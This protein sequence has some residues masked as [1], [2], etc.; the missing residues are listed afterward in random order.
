MAEQTPRAETPRSPNGVAARLLRWPATGDVPEQAPGPLTLELYPTLRCNL[1]CRFCDTTERHRPPVDELST[2]ELERIVDEAAALGV[3]R[4]F[5][6]GG[7]EPLAR[8]DT[9]ALMQRVKEH[10]M[11]G[12]LTT[13][14]TLLGP[15]VA[16]QLVETGWDEV[17]VSL[18]GPSPGVHDP[19]RGQPGAFRKT[20]QAACRLRVLRDRA[21][22]PTPR[23]AVHF[24]L[25]NENWTTLVE[26]VELAHAIGAERI[27]VDALIAY[28]PEQRA[29]C[30]SPEQQT[31]VPAV[32]Q[33][34]LARAEALGVAS[35]LHH[36]LDAATLNRGETAVA[37]APG[38]GLDGAPCLKAWHYLVVQADGRTSPC[39]VLA[40]E[41]GSVR[42]Q[43]LRD[44]WQADPFLL[45]VREGMSRQRPLPRCSECS[46]NILSHEAAIRDALV[47]QRAGR[48][49]PHPGTDPA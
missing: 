5:V 33:Q 43:S 29:L 31:A 26:M 32:A 36:F 46:V 20:V 40:G 49:V 12:I 28:T 25:T 39:C 7:G 19:L 1:D 35:T 42:G 16:R 48:A 8:R 41:G 6:L 30:L 45:R 38:T 23:L 44:V 22:S 2:E 27:D 21:G 4:V 37:G 10:G 18:D 9:P 47:R 24:V 13:N 11:E 3:Q 14:G 34:A 15:K 17:H